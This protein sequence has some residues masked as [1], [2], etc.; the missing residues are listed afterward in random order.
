M[1]PCPIERG[2][3]E[4]TLPP[5]LSSLPHSNPFPV[6]LL[7]LHSNVFIPSLSINCHSFLYLYPLISPLFLIITIHT[8]F[9]VHSGT[10]IIINRIIQLLA[11]M[12]RDQDVYLVVGS[13]MQ[14]IVLISSSQSSFHAFLHLL[15]LPSSSLYSLTLS[16]IHII[17]LSLFSLLISSTFY[18]F[19]TW[20][21]STKKGHPLLIN[22]VCFE[23]E[24]RYV[25]DILKRLSFSFFSFFSSLFSHQ[26]NHSQV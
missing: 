2:Q 12:W 15:F 16:L 21:K 24:N 20:M 7:S 4:G 6:I 1:R 18:L 23:C 17:F 11:S 26:I 9:R 22:S 19:L 25:L 8:P 3:R 14:C 13:C 10:I 5:S